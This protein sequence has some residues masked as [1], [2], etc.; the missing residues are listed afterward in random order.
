MLSLPDF[1]QS[2]R[3][4][5]LHPVVGECAPLSRIGC[6]IAAFDRMKW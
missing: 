1:W 5:A 3:F 2:M 6:R 4:T